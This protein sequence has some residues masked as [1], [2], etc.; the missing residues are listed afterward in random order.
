MIVVGISGKMGSGKTT[1]SNALAA[2]IVPSFQVRFAGPLYECHEAV[3]SI[4]EGYG[5]PREQKSRDFLT[6]L[7][8][9]F[10][11]N[12]QPDFWVKALNKKVREIRSATCLQDEPLVIVDDVRFENEFLGLSGALMVRLECPVDVRRARA[13]AWSDAKHAS[14]IGL[15]EYSRD[16]RFDLYFDTSTRSVESMVSIIKR[17]IHLK[18]FDFIGKDDRESA[19]QISAEHYVRAAEF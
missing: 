4:L 16:G 5:L 19:K 1:L 7:G 13:S 15:D 3:W 17:A 9:E 6:W 18:D 8:T 10:V 14:E 2:E 11:R 12:R